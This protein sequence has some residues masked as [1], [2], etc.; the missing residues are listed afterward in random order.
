ME[1][2]DAARIANSGD[3]TI[4]LE[5]LESCGFIRKYQAFGRKKK[6]A[7][8][9]LMDFFTLFYYQFL[10]EEPTDEHFWTNQINTPARNAWMG[11]AFER[12][13][14]AHV[15]QIKK[16]L[17]ISGVLT[18]VNSWYCNADSEHGIFGSQIDLLIVR[19]DQVINLCEIKYSVSEYTITE[20]TSQDMYRKINDLVAMTGTKYAIYPTWI[21]TF[22]LVQN[23]YASDVQSVIT[24]ADLFQE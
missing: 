3:L 16:A 5:E 4:K 20:K 10:K 6:S 2:I 19:K 11:I 18:Q 12:I 7:V 8:Y 14:L 17:G 13:C 22:G 21:T 9:Q 23:A 15:D 1:L 24:M